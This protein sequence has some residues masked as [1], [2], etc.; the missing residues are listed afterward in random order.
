MQPKPSDAEDYDS[1]DEML[2]DEYEARGRWLVA[3]SEDSRVSIWPL[4][5]FDH[6]S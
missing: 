5:T 4:I 6:Q 3:G 2:P 1:E